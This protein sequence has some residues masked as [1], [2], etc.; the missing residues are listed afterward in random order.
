MVPQSDA[1][2]APRWG[3][4]GARDRGALRIL[5][6]QHLESWHLCYNILAVPMHLTHTHACTQHACTRAHTHT[7]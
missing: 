5:L 3:T 2:P 1:A 7:A 4:R 6:F